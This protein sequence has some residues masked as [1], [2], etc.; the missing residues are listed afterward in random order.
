MPCLYP[1]TG[2]RNKLGQLT[3]SPRYAIDD[4]KI[5][6]RCGQ[7]IE[8]RLRRSAA[9]ATRCVHES[10][11]YARNCFITLT[12][13]PEHI[14][15]GGTLVLK[16]YQDFMKRLRKRMGEGIRFFHCG[17]Y[18][19]KTQRPHY[20]AILFN[21]DFDDKVPW[22][23]RDEYTYY[24]SKILTDLWG[25]GHTAIGEANFLTAA[26]VA[27]YVTKKI[28]GPTAQQH[29]ERLNLQ[30]GEIID[31]KSE[32]VTMSRRPG[33]GKLWFDKYKTDVYPSDEVVIERGD[34]MI[35]LPP[36]KY[37]DGLFELVDAEEMEQVK[38]KRQER[39]K[40]MAKHSTEERLAVR[41]EIITRKLQ[42]LKRGY[43][44][45]T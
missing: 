1:L 33:I 32:Y 2:Y 31:L 30:T 12:Y 36:P 42:Q 39:A 19:E 43:E 3:Q 26:Y 6:V 14:P 27:R 18:G 24:N 16:H 11:L 44:N 15:H 21:M 22:K 34:K 5:T 13:S 4:G 23:V 38:F 28:T 41:E 29:Y 37:Y 17:E 8:C 9:W 45:D 35:K 20:H 7:C 25:Y 40:I 10:S